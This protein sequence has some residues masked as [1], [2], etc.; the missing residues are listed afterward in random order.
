[1]KARLYT[2]LTGLLM[3]ACITTYGQE[4]VSEFTILKTDKD[5]W[6]CDLF[7]NEDGTLMFR[8]LM[9][10]P[11]TYDDYQHLFYKLTP[12][13]EV[14]DSLII[15][16]FADW[17]YLMRDPVE[18]DSYILTEDVWVYDSIGDSYI[19]SF[20][21]IFIDAELNI[22]EDITVPL[23]TPDPSLYYFTWDPWFIDPQNDFIISFW[24]DNEHHLRRVGRD[25]TVKTARDGSAIF[26][27]NYETQVQQPGGDSL[28]L[29]SDM[30]FGTF[31]ES[32]LTY[33]LLGGYYPTSGPWPIIGYF[34]DADF[35]LIDKHVYEEFDENI[36]Y[37]GGNNEHII[38]LEDDSYLIAVQTSRLSPTVGG[39]GVAKLDMNH[40][41]ITASPMF[42]SSHCYPRQT[43]ITDDGLIYQLYDRSSQYKASLVRLNDDLSLDWDITL[44]GT[45]AIAY[46]GTS[47]ILLQNGNLA[48]GYVSRKNMRYCATIV[49]LCDNYDGVTET[50]SIEHPFTLYP[51]PVKNQLSLRFDDG[52]EPESVELYDLTG[53]WVS[54]KRNGLKNID[55][56]AISSGVYMLR[57]TTT[58]GKT[59]RERVIKE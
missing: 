40:N 30:G 18:K 21:M 6:G 5:F 29:Y 57:I 56:N 10:T 53:R 17:D 36:G 19:P 11:N 33:Y 49:T 35:N 59:Y 31:S 50:T 32:P 37:D 9:Y 58:D 1:M 52:V 27:P 16:A 26:A 41:L 14:L 23:Y 28:L 3:A 47:L 8:T 34:F 4:N 15:D 2:I 51:N 7:E 44:P 48:I 24:S 22:N 12:E 54:T 43:A 39:V 25:G 45:Q 20:R 46:F 55:L 13:G 42:G 38:P